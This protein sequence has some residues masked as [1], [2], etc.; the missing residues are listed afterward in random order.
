[1]GRSPWRLSKIPRTP[2]STGRG[3]RSRKKNTRKG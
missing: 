2:K 3:S 1:M